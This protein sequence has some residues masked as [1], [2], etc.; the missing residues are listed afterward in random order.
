[1]GELGTPVSRGRSER[2]RGPGSGSAAGTTRSQ[3][4]TLVRQGGCPFRCTVSPRSRKRPR[5]E[6]QEIRAA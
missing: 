1:M 6:K 5:C 4:A 3:S 2:R